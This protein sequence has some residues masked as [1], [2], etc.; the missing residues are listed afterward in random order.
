MLRKHQKVHLLCI[1]VHIVML[2]AIVSIPFSVI[3]PRLATFTSPYY[4]ETLYKDLERAFNTSQY[5]QENNPG[6]MPDETL[7]SYVAGAYLHGMDPIMA[8]SEHTPLGKYFLSLSI[9]IFH[10]DK[11]IMLLFVLLSGIS[12]WLVSKEVLQH[13]TFALIPVLLVA[14]DKLFLNQLVTVPLLDIIQL[15]FIYLT[16]AAF[17]YE[18]RK[19]LFL[20]TVISIGCVMATKTVVPGIIL[21]I[22]IST[23]LI[24][25]KE[26]KKLFHF[27]G[28]LPLAGVIFTLTYVRT[29]MSGYTFWEFLKFQKWIFLYQK[30]KLIYPFSSF[31]LILFNQWQT[32]W[33]EFSVVAANDWSYLWPVSTIASFGAGIWIAIHK[34]WKSVSND[35]ILLVLLWV[36]TYHGVLSLGVVSSRFFIPVLPAQYI[37]LVFVALFLI[38]HI[39]KK[40]RF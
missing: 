12:I 20:L 37:L 7:F 35:S 34:S 2:S 27:L 26:F 32:W 16:I 38:R 24:L 21:I 1:V 23:F 30:S 36:I 31:R 22:C 9:Y 11:T 3:Y 10:N 18:R 8:N 25:R 4:T 19:N 33:G 17:L 5:R 6:I 40:I 15:P 14:V 13:S 28:W 29:F 39:A